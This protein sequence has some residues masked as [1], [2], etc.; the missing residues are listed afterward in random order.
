MSEIKLY[1]I[2]RVLPR[3]KYSVLPSAVNRWLDNFEDPD[4]KLALELLYFFEYIDYN[5]LL[6]IL[7]KQLANCLNTIPPNE[8]ILIF[9]FG[10]LGKSSIHML[11]PLNKTKTFINNENNIT[12]SSVIKDILKYKHV[13]YIDDFIGSGNSFDDFYNS[14]EYKD[15]IDD[16][17]LVT[18]NLIS[19]IIMDEGMKFLNEKYSYLRIYAEVRYKLISSG[20]FNSLFD[21]IEASKKL[22]KK[23]GRKIRSKPLGYSKSESMIAFYYSTPN[24]TFPIFYYQSNYE[25]LKWTPLFSRLETHKL[26]EAKKLKDDFR[27]FLSINYQLNKKFSQLSGFSSEASENKY[28]HSLVL[29]LFLKN[30]G[31]EDLSICQILSVTMNQ[32]LNIK[33]NA[34]KEGFIINECLTIKGQKLLDEI[35]L[36][37][38]KAITRDEKFIEIKCNKPL[39][40]PSQFNGKS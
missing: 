1:Q 3:L 10:N 37:K 18:E 25:K 6:Y 14:D 38:K 26:E 34:I 30:K 35:N 7:D 15:I 11:Y 16:K 17:N 24:N 32:L 9:P 27:Y 4:K 21:N 19:C 39:Y 8:K 28:K 2:E 36:T 5:E 31:F 40:L 22:L 23:Y 33:N 13:I 20:R 29:F 12:F